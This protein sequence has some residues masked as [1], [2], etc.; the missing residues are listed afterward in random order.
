M[1]AFVVSFANT[2]PWIHICKEFYRFH[3]FCLYFVNLA[4]NR[5]TVPFCRIQYGN[6][7]WPPSIDVP[8][9]ELIRFNIKQVKV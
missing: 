6:S 5:Y 9:K 2:A 7:V 8:Y 4:Q 3:A 1:L